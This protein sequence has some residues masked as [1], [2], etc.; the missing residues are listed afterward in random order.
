MPRTAKQ[1]ERKEERLDVRL[2]AEQK[3]ILKTAS[4]ML[5]ES[6][7]KYVIS[8]AIR[9]A[10]ALIQQ[11]STLRLSARDWKIFER[12]MLDESPPV[13]KL[14]SAAAQYR[15]DCQSSEGLLPDSSLNSEAA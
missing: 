3:E 11:R 12:E 2:T 6:L 15:I 1:T 5:G 8:T 9:D 7:A 13:E 14:R 4:A 10:V